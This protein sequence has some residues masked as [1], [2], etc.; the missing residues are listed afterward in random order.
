VQEQRRSRSFLDS[1]TPGAWRIRPLSLR[2]PLMRR[3]GRQLYGK[4]RHIRGV[5]LTPECPGICPPTPRVLICSGFLRLAQVTKND[6]VGSSGVPRTVLAAVPLDL[7]QRA[8]QRCCIHHLPDLGL[9]HQ[10]SR[11]R[12]ASTF[13]LRDKGYE[14]KGLLGRVRR[15]LSWRTEKYWDDGASCAPAEEWTGERKEKAPGCQGTTAKR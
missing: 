9:L 11:E 7:Y 13:A 12:E 14:P 8:D 5:I 4:S 1:G 2:G 10:L 3:I 6:L 15:P